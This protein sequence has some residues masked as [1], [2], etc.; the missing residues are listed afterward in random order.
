MSDG[1]HTVIYLLKHAELAVRGCVEVALEQFNLTPNQFLMLLRLSHKEGQSA[2]ELARGIGV[3]PQ[4]LTEIINPLADKALIDREESPEHRRVLRIT[5]T[6]AGRQL[7]ARALRIGRQLEKEL[8]ADL[9]SGELAGLLSSLGKILERAQRHE[10]HP[11]VRR[12]TAL[13][14]AKSRIA[15]PLPLN[16][17]ARAR[18]RVG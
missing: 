11:E 8:V 9:D 2:A 15:R 14:L 4:S 5:L 16:R 3:R 13:K 1:P 18:R 12:V 17:R 10:C 7:L 6:A